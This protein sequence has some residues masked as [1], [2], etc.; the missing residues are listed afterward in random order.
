M[1]RKVWGV[2]SLIAVVFLVVLARIGFL[3]SSENVM[4]VGKSSGT[5]TVVVKNLRGTIYDRHMTPLVNSE[6]EY[7]AAFLPSNEILV[8]LRSSMGDAEY[9]SLLRRIEWNVP[10]V[11]SLS[12]PAVIADG[13]RVFLTPTRYE[14]DCLCPHLIGHLDGSAQYGVTGVE[15]AFDSLLSQYSGQ[16]TATFSVNGLGAYQENST[17]LV[18]N[19]LEC[20]SGGVVLSVDREIQCM[21]D[22]TAPQ[23]L[24][25]GAVIVLDPYT[26]EILAGSSFPSYHPEQVADCINGD[27]GSLLN[28]MLS[29]YDCGSVFKIVTAIAALE[30]GVHPQ[31]TFICN[32]S[33]PVDSTTFHCHYRLGHQE[34]TMIEAFAQSC[35]L[36]FIQ[37]AE[38]I[39]AEKLMETA[40]KLGLLDVISLADSMVAPASVLPTIEE[41]SISA[42]L[43][44]FSF[45]QGKLLLSPL[46]VAKITATVAANGT[47]PDLHLINGTVDGEGNL[48]K[49]ENRGGETV[50]S[51]ATIRLLREM[52]E[53]VVSEGTGIRAQSSYVNS[54][55]KTGTAQTGQFNNGE[56]VVQS[57][58]TGYFPAENPKYVVTILAEDAENTKADAAQLFCE[59][60]NKLA[61]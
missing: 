22:E 5:R 9:R 7:L 20:C 45:G 27:D 57:W 28:R 46:H 3:I 29:Q 1:K 26:G 38:E 53:C 19:T 32:G 13:M 49:Y 30:N 14:E 11:A 51:A 55:G 52:M 6:K 58:F 23:Y 39:G 35:N 4:V 60:S 21:V 54:A 41:L 8:N 48:T 61:K 18:S 16:I 2:Y 10:M 40:R 43:A 17:I 12:A 33:M 56:P 50:V 44:N 15:K 31:Q 36:Y 42:A 34:V 25:K 59:I 47:L 37:L 24:E